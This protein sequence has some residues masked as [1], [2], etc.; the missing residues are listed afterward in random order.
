M[1]FII[2]PLCCIKLSFILIHVSGDTTDKVQ[3]LYVLRCSLPNE[4]M[5]GFSLCL[6]LGPFPVGV[7]AELLVQTRRIPPE[8]PVRMSPLLRKARH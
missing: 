8:S 7:S 5:F 4:E 3:R 2:F 1:T 6:P